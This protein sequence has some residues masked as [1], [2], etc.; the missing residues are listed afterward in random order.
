MRTG[1]ISE[2]RQNQPKKHG[3]SGMGQIRTY[4][5][6]RSGWAGTAHATI[7]RTLV[8]LYQTRSIFMVR[9]SLSAIASL[10]ITCSA[11][12]AQQPDPNAPT[13]A[14]INGNIL[15]LDGQSRV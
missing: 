8:P 11:A 7:L 4:A 6:Q 14:L 12:M 2:R 13:L 3:A 15:T 5:Q 1:R 9:R 10:L